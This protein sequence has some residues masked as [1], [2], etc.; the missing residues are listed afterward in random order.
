MGGK[1]QTPPPRD[2]LAL[3]YLCTVVSEIGG[4]LRQT[5][6]H[7]VRSLSQSLEGEGAGEE[8]FDSACPR[9]TGVLSELD[10]LCGQKLTSQLDSMHLI[11]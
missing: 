2:N 3:H 5:R 10:Q 9:A 11:P 1:S 6:C 4:V 8:W 7:P